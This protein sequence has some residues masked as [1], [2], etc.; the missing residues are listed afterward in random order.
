MTV[1]Y[2][3]EKKVP[4]EAYGAIKIE[5]GCFTQDPTNP[6]KCNLYTMSKADLSMVPNFGIKMMLRKEMIGK[7]NA[8]VQSF[9]KS[10]HY[11]TLSK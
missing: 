5:S 10:K 1:P 7:F 6:N 11:E 4:V 3:A 2:D 8:M 9:K